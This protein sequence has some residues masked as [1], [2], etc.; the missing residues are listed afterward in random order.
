MLNT[1]R[2]LKII[3]ESY[4]QGEGCISNTERTSGD[5]SIAD[6]LHN[7]VVSEDDKDSDLEA[8]VCGKIYTAIEELRETL[9]ALID[10]K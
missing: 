9:Q 8:I 4:N 2:L 1:E 3:D 6:F 10:A 7:C 5:D